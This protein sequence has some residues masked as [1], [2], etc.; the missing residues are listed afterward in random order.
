MAIGFIGGDP[1]RPFVTDM[2]YNSGNP[3]SWVLPEH[4]ACPG[5]LTRSFPDGQIGNKLRFDSM[6]DTRLVYLHAQKMFSYDVEDAHM[7]TIIGEDDGALTLEKN[8]RITT[9][10]EDNDALMLEKGDRSIELKEGDGA[11][12][13]EKGSRSTT[14]KEGGD[15]LSP[16]K[17]NRAVMLKEGNDLLMLGKDG[18]TVELKDG[19]GG[20]KVKGKRRV[21]TGGSE[22]CKHGGNVAINAKGD[23]MLRA[24]DNLT[25]EAGGTLAFKSAKA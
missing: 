13:I 6:K 23:Y 22:E 11:S 4:A 10:K 7:V 15:A 20:L 19:D 14:L 12:T 2:V 25:T 1:D 21:G 3:P 5:L 9:L 8:S 17:G 24:S 18:R 16:E